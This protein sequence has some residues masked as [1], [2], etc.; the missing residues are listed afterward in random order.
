MVLVSRGGHGGAAGTTSILFQGRIPTYAG[1]T[2]FL[3][4]TYHLQL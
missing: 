3:L 4:T 2:K 1:V